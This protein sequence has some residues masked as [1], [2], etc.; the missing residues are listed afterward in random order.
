MVPKHWL[1]NIVQI[2]N[3]ENFETKFWFFDLYSVIKSTICYYSRHHF[4][5]KQFTLPLKKNEN[6]FFRRLNAFLKHFIHDN[7]V[8][9]LEIVRY[10]INVNVCFV[11]DFFC[12]SIKKWAKIWAWAA[13]HQY[14]RSRYCNQTLPILIRCF[15]T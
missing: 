1:D 10:E 4:V 11:L 9:Q 6:T 3:S 14:R 5:N 8:Y 2:K 12:K 13:L 7:I 15:T